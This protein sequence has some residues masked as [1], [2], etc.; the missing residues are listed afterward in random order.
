M[1]KQPTIFPPNKSWNQPNTGYL[2][3]SIYQTQNVTMDIAGVISLSRKTRAIGRG[4]EVGGTFDYLLSIAFDGL[5]TTGSNIYYLLTSDSLYNLFKDLTGFTINVVS[6]QPNFS[7]NSSD[8]VMWTDGLYCSTS[9]NVS[10][11]SAGAW[12]GSQMSFSTSAIPHPLCVSASANY[13]LGGNGNILRQKDP[14]TGTVTTALTLPSNYRIQWIRSD[15]SRTFIGCRNM[16]GGNTAVFEWDEVSP[17]WTNKYDIDTQWVYSGEFRNTDFFVVTMDGR[18]L[19][20][21]GG[22]FGETARFPIYKTLDGDWKNNFALGVVFQRGMVTIEGR[23]HILISAQISNGKVNGV[24]S[25]YYPNFIGGVWEFDE[26]TGLNHKYGATYGQS[27]YKDYAQINCNPGAMAQVVVDPISSS[28]AEADGSILLFG[29]LVD[30]ENADVAERYYVLNSATL[31]GTNRGSFVTTRVET[32]DVSDDFKKLWV[33]SRGLYT[34]EDK[35]IFKVKEVVRNGIPFT[36]NAAVEWSSTTVFTTP[37]SGATQWEKVVAGD[38]VT[39]LAGPGAGGAANIV[40][41]VP[42]GGGAYT[43]TLDEAIT[44]MFSGFVSLVTVDNFR[45]LQTQITSSDEQQWKGIPLEQTDSRN[46]IQIKV[47]MRG[48][49]FVTIE[50]MQLVSTTH[51]LPT[52]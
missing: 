13:L 26:S 45:R 7:L 42:A 29:A 25:E 34:G 19:K 6:S 15:Y 32:S 24:S 17:S 11:L 49:S 27:N 30:G 52:V 33:K 4:S 31:V 37:V 40:S 5:S 9:S 43:V 3:G 14:S 21:N 8:A 50:E 47:E 22:G 2:F 44:G 36:S 23:L 18:V 51:V 46:W 28:P 16:N 48:S 39:N 12:T 1:I 20:F 10:K 41:I 38:E 35:L